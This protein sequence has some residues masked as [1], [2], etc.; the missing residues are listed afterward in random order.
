MKS[1][2]VLRRLELLEKKVMSPKQ[3]GE[4]TVFVYADGTTN[5]ASPAEYEGYDKVTF[6]IEDELED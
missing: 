1:K 5:P 6:I 4:I 3:G 2:S